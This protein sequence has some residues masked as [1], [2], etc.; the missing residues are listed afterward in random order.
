MYKLL[1]LE[2]IL[3]RN[4][5]IV[6]EYFRGIFGVDLLLAPVEYCAGTLDSGFTGISLS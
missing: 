5:F 4:R 2:S 3:P 1:L 6:D